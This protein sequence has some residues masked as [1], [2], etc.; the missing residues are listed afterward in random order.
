MPYSGRPELGEVAA[1]EAALADAFD[2]TD[3]PTL[4][5]SE[6]AAELEGEEPGEPLHEPGYPLPLVMEEGEVEAVEKCE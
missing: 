1:I 2:A 3:A 6:L 4:A 5:L